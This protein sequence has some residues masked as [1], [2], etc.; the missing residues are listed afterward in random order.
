MLRAMRGAVNGFIAPVAGALLPITALMLPVLLLFAALGVDFGYWMMAKRDLQT[1]ADSAA[2]SAMHEY[3][4]GEFNEADLTAVAL[5]QAT[6]NGYTSPPGGALV[7][8]V[9]DPTRIQV[10]IQQPASRF[11]SVL[12]PDQIITI[13][14]S[15]TAGVVPGTGNYCMLALD[16]SIDHAVEFAGNSVGS[17]SCGVAAK[18][19]SDSALFVQSTLD[20]NQVSVAGDIEVQGVGTLNVD[21]PPILDAYLVDPYEDL[22]VP[23]APAGCDYN[24]KVVNN[25]SDVVLLPGRYCNGLRLT[26]ASNL[27]FAPGVY[28]IDSG[29]F[30]STLNSTAT[31]IGVTFILTETAASSGSDYA[32][33][34]FTGNTAMNL[35]APDS[36]PYSGILFYQDRDAPSFQGANLIEDSVGGNTALN[37]SG[38][39]YFP[40]QELK[41]DGHAVLQ[42]GA[43]CL[44]VIGR[45]VTFLGDSRITSGTCDGA[46]AGDVR[47][48]EYKSV[49]LIL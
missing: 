11:F 46:N 10:D 47:P 4:N 8:T 42:S 7:M 20:T 3:V 41:F 34:Q 16:E 37:F 15:A 23:V 45:K 14:V 22:E 18:S 32:S 6:N 49:R 21:E 26:N 25:Q 1:A 33:L 27:T 48:I 40:S 43:S 17:I 5:R 28:I 24:N 31:G 39:M 44:Q 13:A 29:E 30:Q 19:N 12:L 2:L 9:L 35:T 36:G 38:A